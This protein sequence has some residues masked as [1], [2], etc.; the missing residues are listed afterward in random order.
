MEKQYAD[1]VEAVKNCHECG[2]GTT[3][4]NAVPGEGNIRATLM[5]VGEGPGADEDDQ[6]RP[7]VGR[8]GQLLTKILESVNI[9]REEVYITNVVKCRPPNNRVPLPAEVEACKRHL[10]KQIAVIKPKLIGALGSTAAK[11]LL[12]DG[13]GTISKIRG[14]WFDFED[15]IKLMP[16]FHP[17]YLLRNP[18]KEPGSPKHQMWGDMK[19]LKAA[20]DSLK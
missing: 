3:R 5:F 15:G 10:F 14:N 19:K 1:I 11:F 2:L 12:G 8:A 7:F 4:K 20:Y 16:L 18:S 13:I 6:G 17:S 9:T